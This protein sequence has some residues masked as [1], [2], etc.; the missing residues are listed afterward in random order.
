MVFELSNVALTQTSQYL[1][2]YLEIIN[3]KLKAPNDNTDEEEILTGTDDIFS[4]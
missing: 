1:K 4:A 3:N 2:Q